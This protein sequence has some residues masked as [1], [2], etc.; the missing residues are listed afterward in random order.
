MSPLLIFAGF[1]LLFL[2]YQIAEAN[3][4]DLL[5]FPGK[6]Y[7]IFGLFAIVIPAAD[8][9]ARWQNAPGL[10]AYG[11]GFQ[12]GWW[13]NYLF[14]LGLGLTV[15]S[16]LE[17]V[18]VKLGI[19]RVSNLHFSLRTLLTSMLW[20]L[21]ANFPA[22]A[23]EDLITRGYLWHFMT[24]SPLLVF[25]IGSTLVYTFNHILRL[26]TRPVTDWYYLPLIGLTLAYAL[27][28][29]GSLWLVIG[30]HQAGNAV[31]FVMHKIM[32]LSNIPVT[33][34]RVLFGII[35]ELVLLAVV[36]AAI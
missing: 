10:S 18:G 26:L 6:P 1:L 8:L 4:Q 20:I 21:F 30:L 27:F 14:G 29:T 34:D 13:Q 9:V 32:D 11:L 12:P 28:H 16:L 17:F 5:K 22:A 33:K 31:P 24:S 23:A 35:S 36:I 15:Q 25:M 3:G 2:L 19:R 7:S